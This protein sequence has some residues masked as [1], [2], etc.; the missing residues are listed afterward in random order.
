MHKEHEEK[1]S[2][3]LKSSYDQKKF[4]QQ[5][6]MLES[7]NTSLTMLNN[8][9][10]NSLRRQQVLLKT[11]L[12]NTSKS[13]HRFNNSPNELGNANHQS[14]QNKN[15]NNVNNG[16]LKSKYAIIFTMDSML[17]YEK[18]S[19]NGGAAGEIIVRSCLEHVLKLLNVS[20]TIAR[21]DNEFEKSIISQ[22][23]FIIL[24]PWTWAAKGWVTKPNIRGFENR[25]YILDFFGSKKMRGSSLNIPL[26]R[27]L[28]A[29]G[30]PWNSF[31]GYFITDNN[32]DE[33]I[34]GE[35]NINNAHNLA[36][37]KKDQGVIWGKDVR[38]FE[39]RISMLEYAASLSPLYSTVNTEVFQHNNVHWLGHQSSVKWK[40][41]LLES[42]F[43]IGLG[44][45]LLGPSAI[46]AIGLGCMYI[47]PLIPK[48]FQGRL[49]TSQHPYAVDN[50]GDPYV[51]SF[52]INSREQLK[53]CIDK[54]LSSNLKPFIPRDFTLQAHI[55]RVKHIF[56][57]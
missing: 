43:L 27:I 20:V 19:M 37:T 13:I 57:L 17:D 1:S 3:F 56:S 25:I 2:E 45:P 30:S 42:K 46:D 50:I 29:F 11:T 52:E 38:H 5:L 33:S 28:T 55:D 15:K 23:D 51:C 34:Q 22:Y 24:D 21:S 8:R 31:L 39:Q 49:F 9:L 41:L 12:T 53:S 48:D 44:D 10:H 16:V 36:S 4:N 47:N 14:H 35:R 32:I 26:N 40:Q 7:M 6:L 18:N 54:A